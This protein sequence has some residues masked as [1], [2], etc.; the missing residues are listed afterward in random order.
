MLGNWASL[1][2]KL[3]VPFT[4]LTML[5]EKSYSNRQATIELLRF[6]YSHRLMTVKTLKEALAKMKRDDV[7]KIFQKFDYRRKSGKFDG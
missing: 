6:L 1:A 2:L 5:Q 7:L 3:G 4:S